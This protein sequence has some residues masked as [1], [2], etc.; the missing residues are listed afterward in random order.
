MPTFIFYGFPPFF[1]AKVGGNVAFIGA[2]VSRVFTA[3]INPP[4]AKFP[5]MFSAD[6]QNLTVKRIKSAI[7]EFL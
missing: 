1:F 5:A 2:R 3:L 6:F 4:P 7:L